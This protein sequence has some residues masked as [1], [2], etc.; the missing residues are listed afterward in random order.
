MKVHPSDRQVLVF[1][2]GALTLA[3]VPLWELGNKTLIWPQQGILGT[4]EP[5]DPVTGRV[6]E[7]P[8]LPEVEVE[9]I[10]TQQPKSL[11]VRMPDD[12]MQIQQVVVVDHL[13][14]A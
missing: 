7:S 13:E 6:S 8:P 11:L 10:N 4:K 1:R 5:A 14:L 9:Q 12:T 2:G 3:P